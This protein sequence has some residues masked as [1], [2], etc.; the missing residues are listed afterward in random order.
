[1]YAFSGAD[2]ARIPVLPYLYRR[3]LLAFASVVAIAIALPAVPALAQEAGKY[4]MADGTKTDDL[5]KAATSWRTPEFLK[6]HALAGVKA[7]YAYAY[8]ITGKSVVL[9]EVDSGVFAFHPQLLGKF[10]PLTVTGAYG[11]DGWRYE[12]DGHNRTWKAGDKFSISG[13]YDVLIN[14]SHGTAAAGEMVAKRDGLEMHGIAIDAHLLSAN[15]GGTDGS[16][17]GPNVDYD[18]FKEAYGVL[19]RNGA[20]AINSSWGQEYSKAGDYGTIEGL[21]KLYNMFAGKKTFLD[22]AFEVS[23]EYGAIQVWANG[24]EGRNN[25]RAVVAMP[26]FRPEVEPYWIGVTGVTK[27][28][29]SIYDRCGVTK[30]WCMAGPTVDIYSTS[31]RRNGEDYDRGGGTLA[32]KIEAGYTP[33]YNGTSAAAPNVTASLGLVMARFSYL[34]GPRRAMFCLPRQSILPIIALSTTI[35]RHR[36]RCSVGAG[37]I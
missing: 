37:L 35:S 15:S 13:N 29:A 18:Y 12:E 24:N 16:I 25:P 34:T 1:M 21:T 14:D 6:D 31:V 36:M 23:K 2:S 8:G 22:A 7:E 26:Y 9:G 30:Y 3:K 4:F 11:A 19:A 10:T 5:E 33:E 20:R 27:D 28:G 17:F 32:D